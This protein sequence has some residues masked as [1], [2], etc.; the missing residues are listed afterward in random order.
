VSYL[1]R[2]TRSRSVAEPPLIVNDRCCAAWY[3]DGFFYYG[4]V[5][6]VSEDKRYY[7]VLFDDK[8]SLDEIHWTHI[9]SENKG[10]EVFD[11]Q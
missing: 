3:N 11:V 8:V 9:Y 4:V 10:K 6:G 7:S 1:G 5:T 2:V